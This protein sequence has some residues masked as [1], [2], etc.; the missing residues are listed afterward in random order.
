MEIVLLDSLKLVSDLELYIFYQFLYLLYVLSFICLLLC[1]HVR[2][3][4]HKYKYLLKKL[5]TE[6]LNRIDF[7]FSGLL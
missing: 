6:I 7:A 5:K 2:Y 3:F 4:V 1:L